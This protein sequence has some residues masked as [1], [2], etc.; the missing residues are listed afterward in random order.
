[1]LSQELG[2]EDIIFHSMRYVMQLHTSRRERYAKDIVRTNTID[3][4]RRR[5]VDATKKEE[6]ER[7]ETYGTKTYVT[8]DVFKC[9]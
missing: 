2:P 8:N 5:R 4:N 9:V 1:M 6:K 7:T 3:A